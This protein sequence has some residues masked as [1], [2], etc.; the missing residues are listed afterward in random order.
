MINLEALKIVSNPIYEDIEGISIDNIIKETLF[1]DRYY[2]HTV[3]KDINKPCDL[4]VF[5]HGSRDIAWTQVLEYTNLCSL[6]D[7]YIVAF[8]QALRKYQFNTQ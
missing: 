7:N 8:G 5:Y 2:L 3:P 6:S 1:N 4:I